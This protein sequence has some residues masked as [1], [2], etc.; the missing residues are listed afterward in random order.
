MLN[1]TLLSAQRHDLPDMWQIVYSKVCSTICYTYNVN[2]IHFHSVIT[3]E[4]QSSE[5][6]I[7]IQQWRKLLSEAIRKQ[8]AFVIIYVLPIWVSSK[9][10]VKKVIELLPMVF[11]LPHLKSIDVPLYVIHI[12]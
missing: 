8:V 2:C 1:P 9:G 4:I 11:P 7:L 5:L 12:M 6:A 3:Q 10:I